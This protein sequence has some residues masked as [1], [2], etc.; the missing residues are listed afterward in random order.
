MILAHKIRITT[1]AAQETYFKKAC[2]TARF[3]YNW[4]LSAWKAQYQQGDTPSAYSL[5]KQFNAIKKQAFPWISD[6]TK[7]ASEGAFMNLS[8]AFTNFF[9]K[10]S[11]FPKFKRSGVHDSFYLANDQIRLRSTAIKIPKLGWVN[12]RE[13][14]RFAGKVMSAIVSRIADRWF[15]SISVEV[16]TAYPQCENQA[17]V[18]VD[19]GIKT[20][21][22]LS[23]GET[24]E[25]PRAL[26]QY[27]RRLKRYQRQLQRKQ[28]GSQNREKARMKVARLYDKIRCLRQDVTHK[29]TTSLT[30]RF[31]TIVIEDLNV[32]GMLK[33]HK[34]AKHIS[35]ANFG[36]IFRQL[37]YKAVL[38]GNTVT[39]VH[40]FFP[41]SKTCSRCGYV[42]QDLT[43]ADRTFACPSCGLRLDRDVNAACNLKTIGTAQPEFTL[44][45]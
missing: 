11:R 45:D 10:H 30:Q 14:L 37:S 15:V 35:D 40:R 44:A 41:S 25:N 8:K 5:K 3:T 36:E 28:N 43:L 6:V 9:A 34:L 27:E 4:G 21:A 32:N 38:R 29:F 7:C 42:K 16:S 13:P 24:W 26:R 33:N 23:T 17:T 20:L 19:V 1:T 18:G 31:K 2:G 22:T 12:M 39:N